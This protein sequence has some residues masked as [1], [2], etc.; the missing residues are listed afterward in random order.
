MDAEEDKVLQSIHRTDGH[1]FM[2]GFTIH[3]RAS[4]SRTYDPE[5]STEDF[6]DTTNKLICEL[7]LEAAEVCEKMSKIHTY[8]TCL[9]TWV[10]PRDFLTIISSVGLPLTTI[11]TV[12]P[13]KQSKL[14]SNVD[15]LRIRD[16][17][18]DPNNLFG[19]EATKQLAALVR[20]WMQN[21]LLTTQW[22]Y[23]MVACE[24]DFKLGRT[25]FERVVSGK[26]QRGG[27]EYRKKRKLRPD[28]QPT[29]ADKPKKKRENPV[30]R[31]QVKTGVGC[32][33]CDKVCL[34][35]ETLSIHVNN[36][37]AD[38]QSLFQCAFCGL[39]INDFRLYNQH[40]NEHSDKVHKCHMCSEQFDNARSL[41]KHIKSHIN[42]CPL[43]SRVFESLFV[44]SNHVNKEHVDALQGDQKKCPFC[45]VAFNT[46]DELRIHCKE[47]RLFSC[48]ICYTEFVSEPLLMEHRFN[49][50][51]HGRPAWSAPR[52]DT[53]EITITKEVKPDLEKAMEAI[54][55]TDPDLFVDKWHPAIGHVKK[56]DNH[57]KECDVCHRYLKTSDSWVEHVNTFHPT[58]FYD[59]VFC[60]GAVFY[61]LRD[62]LSH[63]KKNHFV[64][65][66]C[67]SAH[68]DKNSLK[69]HMVT[70]HPEQPAQAGSEEG[71]HK[72]FV[73]GRCSMYCSTATTF[74]VN[75]ATHKK[76][77]CPFCP[78]KF[79]DAASWNKH[80]SV[81]HSD[82]CERKLNC[83]LALN[84]KQT[85]N[86]MKELGIHSRQAHWKMFPFRCNY[87]DCFDCYRMI[88]ALVKHS[89]LMER[90]HGM[91]P[92]TQRTRRIGT[93]VLC[94]R[95]HLTKLLSY[96]LTPRY[97]RKI[98]TSVMSVSG[99]FI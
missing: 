88:D 45:D 37:H 53:P 29:G 87:K 18:P 48:D 67:D 17:M 41:R 49:D 93:S 85:F 58:V 38:K 4:T 9:K 68:N 16:H 34:N 75:I 65:H 70:E 81:K 28:E 66:Q 77:P 96:C 80:V 92:T 32:K 73:C 11:T 69:Q 8:I 21:Y 97:M 60:P 47:H 2:T 90:R 99:I 35:E 46:F 13:A 22:Q 30:D 31:G 24:S 59:C 63:C 86:N 42:Q 3:A 40:I 74:R 76:T 51:P 1:H 43:C 71:A 94:V 6:D 39:R 62:L 72:G 98:S 89:G 52:A 82:R 50:H 7:H 79:Y 26:K 25:K 57:K 14:D 91:Q 61:T 15:A 78:Q 27:H 23:S 20:Y 44:L 55:T 56:D 19:N 5:F 83:R 10:S 64:C 84:C 33:Y 54:R 12:D 36:K 95:K